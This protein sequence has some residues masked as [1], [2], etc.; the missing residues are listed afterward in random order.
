M[1]QSI[2]KKF[3]PSAKLLDD[4]IFRL[5]TNLGK[6]HSVSPFGQLY[7]KYQFSTSNSKQSAAVEEEKANP[8]ASNVE[9]GKQEEEKKVEAAEKPKQE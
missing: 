8:V 7:Q 3:H 5:E 9:K 2:L 6:G 1:A 4:M